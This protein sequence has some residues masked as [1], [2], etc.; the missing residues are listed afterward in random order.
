MLLQI[1]NKCFEGCAHCL[2][3]SASDGEH[4]SM[5]TFMHVMQWINYG[6]F[7]YVI[8]SGGEP[9]ES[10]LFASICMELN[11]SYIPF[12]IASNGMWCISDERRK[13]VYDVLNLPRCEYMQVYSN[14]KWYKDYDLVTKSDAFS[15]AKITLITNDILSMQ[16]LGRARTNLK[17]QLEVASNKHAPSCLK[18]TMLARQT[19]SLTQFNQTAEMLRVM[20]PTAAVVCTPLVDIKGDVH[21]SESHHCPSCGNVVTDPFDAIWRKMHT[22]NPCMRC[23]V[24]KNFKSS[25]SFNAIQAAKILNW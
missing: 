6:N 2:Q 24:A 15:H 7:S 14:S 9:T 25:G 5:D 17:A 21:M 12:T 20:R 16:D 11:R 19:Y 8:V 10:P 1:T 18:C 22:T 4:M 23:Q 3:S 13:I